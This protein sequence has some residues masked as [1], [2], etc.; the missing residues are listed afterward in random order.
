MENDTS[1]NIKLGIFV[2]LGI[3]SLVLG[4]YFIGSNKNMFSSNVTIYTNFKDVSG[5]I[6]GNN[7]R[8]Y[9]IDIGTVDNIQ[10]NNETSVTVSMI[11]DEK[12]IKFIRKNAQCIIGTDGLMGNKLINIISVSGESEF[13]ED[14]DV[15][16]SKM[17]VSMQGL[18]STLDSTNQN[19]SLASADIKNITG[20]ISSKQNI[21]NSLIYDKALEQILQN[22]IANMEKTSIYLSRFAKTSQ[23][24]GYEINSGKG[25]MHKLIRDTVIVADLNSAIRNLNETSQKLSASSQEVNS[26]VSKASN[27]K[28]TIS[29]LVNDT[30]MPIDIRQSMSYLH[31]SS[32]SLSEVLE[33]LKHNFLL[34]GYFRKLERLKEE[35]NQTRND[36][37][38]N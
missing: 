33:A 34:R 7:V 11:M 20:N 14:N 5:L 24:L 22:T 2:S 28:G 23:D 37:I 31:T 3:L 12:Y 17:D 9:G 13:V 8:Y 30:V 18:L 19:F 16:Q 6:A 27:G 35:S 15:L 36:T 26:L 29:L 38:Q 21:I 1:N 10:M 25:L 4:L 32:L